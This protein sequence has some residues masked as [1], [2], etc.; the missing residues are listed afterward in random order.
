MLAGSMEYSDQFFSRH[1]SVSHKWTERSGMDSTGHGPAHRILTPL[2]EVMVE[3]EPEHS[4][5]GG[6]R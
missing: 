3:E 6:P 1:T 4:L 2:G 5:G